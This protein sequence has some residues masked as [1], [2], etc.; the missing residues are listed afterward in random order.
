M[1]IKSKQCFPYAVIDQESCR[2]S[3]LF[4]FMLVYLY[5][6]PDRETLCRC[7]EN[8]LPHGTNPRFNV[9]DYCDLQFL[10]AHRSGVYDVFCS[11]S[12]FYDEQ[13]SKRSVV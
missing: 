8:L 3:L 13:G 10:A 4:I 6:M 2:A 5:I 11:G 9:H 1:A 7:C 12:T